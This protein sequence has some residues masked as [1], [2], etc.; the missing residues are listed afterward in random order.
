MI[1]FMKSLMKSSSILMYLVHYFTFIVWKERSLELALE[2]G[3]G[4][5]LGLRVIWISHI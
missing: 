2:L 4:L 5:G 1:S 3:L